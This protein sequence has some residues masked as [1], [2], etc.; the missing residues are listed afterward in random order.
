MVPRSGSVLMR[1]RLLGRD[2]ELAAL[3]TEL[4]AAAGGEGRV[5][6]L[7]GEAG[8][9]KTRLSAA[10]GAD[11]R[12]RG[13]TVAWGR[14][15][16]GEG[17]PVYWPWVQAL[18]AG[19]GERSGGAAGDLAALLPE[20]RSTGNATAGAAS[21]QARFALF[22]RVAAAL[23]GA[24][25]HQPL[26]VI[27]DDLHWADAG[28]LRLLEFIG[29]EVSSVP[30]VV[31]GTLRDAEPSAAPELASV[32]STLTRF[33]RR[34]ALRGLAPPAVR[35]LL[36]DRWGC[37][38]GDALVDDVVTV[39]GGNPFLV[40]EVADA[41][42]GGED[43]LASGAPRAPSRVPL[44]SGARELLRR[45]VRA[46][47]PASIAVLE[48]A[49]VMGNEFDVDTVT[50][51]LGESPRAVFDALATAVRHGVVRQVPDMLRRY[52]FTH[53][54]V[55][56]S[57]Y[58]D[59][60]PSGRVGLHAAIADALEASGGAEDDR[61]PLLARHA[62]E[63]AQAGDASKAVRHQLAA[64]ARA[65]RQLAFEEAARCFERVLSTTAPGYDDAR[66]DAVLG[67]GEALHG[68]GD[69]ERGSALLREAVD[70]ARRQGPVRFAETVRRVADVR[71]E[72]GRLDV[73]V[74]ALLEEAVAGLPPG[75]TTLRPRL[76]AR[77]AAGLLLQPGAQMRRKAVA[78]EA[79]A[80]ARQLGDP[81]CLEFVLSRRLVALLGP[82]TLHDRI[83][84]V[85][86]LLGTRP[87]SRWVELEALLFRIDDLAER[88]DRA[89][90]DHVLATFEQ[91][92]SV[93]RHP[94]FVWATATMRAGM[95][96]LEGRFVEGEALAQEALRI[97]QSTQGLTAVLA[98]AQQ[99]F[100]IRG[101][102][103]RLAEV[104][105]WLAA[106]VADT[107]VVPAWRCGLADLY[108]LMGRHAE[109]RREF[110]ALAG[111][112]FSTI[113]RDA[114][115]LTAM[116]LLAGT[117]VRLGDAPRA[118]V[119]YDL[120][121]PYADRI[122]VAR[123]LVVLPGPIA[124]HLGAL[125]S[126]LERW[127]EAEQ[128]FAAALALAERMRGLPWQADIRHQWALMQLRRGQRGDR[129][130]ARTQLDRAETI[131]W[132]LGMDL[133]LG[134]IADA[135][136]AAEQ[137]SRAVGRAV[138]DDSGG[139]GVVLSLVPRSATAAGAPDGSR[140]AP[141]A[142]TFRREG[143]LWTV[144][145]EGRTIRLRHMIGLVHLAAL[146]R[147]PGRAVHVADL[148]DSAYETRRDPPAAAGRPAGDA[149][150]LLD[151]K[152]R[153]EYEARLRVLRAEHDEAS[154]LNDRGR[155]E[156]L[157][158]E[159][160]FLAAELA[161]GYGLS[162]RPRRAGS[163]TE[164]A[165]VAVVRAVKYAIDKIGEQDQAL[166]EHLRLGVRTGTL[167]SYTPPSRDAVSWTL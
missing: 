4:E 120:M 161:R 38:P 12:E 129:E 17:A 34:V 83:A 45:R 113:P 70:R 8:I 87:T 167:C 51:A 94:F 107:A 164:R 160:E 42:A 31:L 59:L 50:T 157:V 144:V 43:R 20:L 6:L 124:A 128:H 91:K 141:A 57:V 61:L 89:G 127:R 146:L 67:L 123:P 77:L 132:Q 52:T 149:G 116:Y 122:A 125:A 131:A 60:A 41:L 3:R 44:T 72:T 7:L 145:F 100:M 62:F 73:E 137:S 111:E 28:S 133:L 36:A 110:D 80:L 126:L 101:W 103:A 35:G 23:T 151:A 79:T 32:L 75:P 136:S 15:H 147:Q 155:A 105:P 148:V 40:L 153:A 150:E 69:L 55:R 142:N 11:A 25:R 90:V 165:R 159:I 166:A 86:E 76:L 85:D 21:A 138:G 13:F 30:L 78:D 64:G 71:V 156:R 135:R 93:V 92:A 84:T 130:R 163:S 97:G 53:A 27:L 102:Q 118:A 158:E 54:L 24:A 162:G 18:R 95:A 63:A 121:L 98:F 119:L 108:E 115:W 106:G 68:C 29:P 10:V 33:G 37:E 5:V 47:P 39:T 1:G 49:A 104:E 82:D 88:G 134:W 56:E 154:R 99:L 9:G 117:C 58:E 19:I 143:D 152:A 112:E 48:V 66:L 16:E 74:N 46:L 139:R 140:T 65:L 2:A 114:A 109:A 22:D 96:L 14:C 26:L 81:A